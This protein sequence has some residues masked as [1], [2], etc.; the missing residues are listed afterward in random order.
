MFFE[1]VLQKTNQTEVRVKKVI[2]KCDKLYGAWKGYDNS[3]NSLTDKK[4]II[5]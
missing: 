4:V 3:F 1:K 5:L 2:Q